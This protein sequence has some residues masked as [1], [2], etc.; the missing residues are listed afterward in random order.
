MFL[1]LLLGNWTGKGGREGR[2]CLRILVTNST[3]LSE[4]FLAGGVANAKLGLD[5]YI[6]NWRVVLGIAV[7]KGH[8][9]IAPDNVLD[10]AGSADFFKI[11]HRYFGFFPVLEKEKG[12]IVRLQ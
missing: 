1:L 6:R 9:S 10:V 4:L 7:A 11:L 2:G 5:N 12:D 8:E 3:V